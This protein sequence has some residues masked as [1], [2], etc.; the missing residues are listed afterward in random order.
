M[1]ISFVGDLFISRRLTG[2][3]LSSLQPIRDIFASHDCSFA[4]LETTLL[5]VNEGAP[6]LFPGGG[7]AMADPACLDDV[8]RIGINLF[9]AA[10]NHAMDYGEDGCLKTIE[11]LR[12][13]GVAFAGIGEDLEHAS[14]PAYF[15]TGDKTIGLVSVTSSFHD[16]YAAGPSNCDIKGRP[17]VSPLRHKARYHLPREQFDQLAKIAADTG[18]NNYHDMARRE[19]Y[20]LPSENLKFGSFEFAVGV[21]AGVETKPLEADLQ[22]TLASID[23]AKKHSDIVIVSVHSHQFKGTDKDTPPDFITSFCKACIDRGAKIVAC[24][25]PHILRGNEKYN[26]GLILHGLGNFIFQHEQQKV[27]PEDFYRKYG[28]TRAEC[29]SPK[30]VFDKRSKGGTV[31]I[32]ASQKEWQSAIFSVEIKGE[33]MN[34]TKYPIDISKETGLPALASIR[35][36]LE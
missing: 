12:A 2:D 16:S 9:N 32:I 14:A 23:E 34:L 17:G 27:V 18:I 21:F 10:N 35:R 13:R 4:N 30:D 33:Y 26:G 3:E 15:R 1:K 11:N 5:N 25:G 19:G 36:R 6:A 7:Y 28:M 22:R 20:L 31:G 29:S 24:H 8:C